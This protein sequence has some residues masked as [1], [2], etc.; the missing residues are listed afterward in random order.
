MKK[1]ISALIILALFFIGIYLKNNSLSLILSGIKG[2]TQDANQELVYRFYVFGVIPAGEAVFNNAAKE[3]YKGTEVLR[4]TARAWSLRGLSA[5]FK[6][7][8]TIE[9]LIDAHTFN[10][11]LFRQ[12]FTQNGS[13][14]Q[15]KEVLY[16]QK[17]RFMEIAG[18]KREILADTQDPL[19]A[20]F[21]IR[22]MD[23]EKTGSF[24]IS[25]NTNQKN[26]VLSG[27]SSLKELKG[28]KL[29]KLTS[30]IKRRDKNP[31]HQSKLTMILVKD[32]R[33]LPVLIKVFASGFLITA[34]LVEV[35]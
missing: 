35:K 11:V 26:Y 32:S 30:T 31:Y 23:F 7:Q 25:I 18:V 4:L 15:F 10:P 9:S 6:G 1:L 20:I 19:S 24:E 3:E 29:V 33:N 5:F 21:N 8:A 13:K 28:K 14:R 34:K 17:D 16:D 12:E 27:K 22:R 2:N